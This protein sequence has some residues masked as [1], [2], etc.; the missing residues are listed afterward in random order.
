MA[1]FPAPRAPQGMGAVGEKMF[2]RDSRVHLP[3]QPLRAI[4]KQMS[5]FSPKLTGVP[6]KKKDEH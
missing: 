6:G 2:G 1:K 5:S 4:F 3:R